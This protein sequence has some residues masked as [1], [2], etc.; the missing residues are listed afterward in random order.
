M[1]P[2]LSG[3]SFGIQKLGNF[4]SRPSTMLDTDGTDLPPSAADLIRPP[5]VK[6]VNYRVCHR[7][8]YMGVSV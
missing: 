3:I 6:R 5:T 4:L 2:L 1:V 7:N 8:A